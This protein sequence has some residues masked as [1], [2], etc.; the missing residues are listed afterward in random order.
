MELCI[1]NF[2]VNI[3]QCFYMYIDSLIHSSCMRTLT[4]LS[5]KALEYIAKRHLQV[6]YKFYGYNLMNFKLSLTQMLFL[7]LY[8]LV[9]DEFLFKKYCIHSNFPLC[10]SLV[11]L[12]FI[13]V[14]MCLRVHRASQKYNNS[15]QERRLYFL[16][17]K[18]N[19]QSF[20]RLKY[21]SSGI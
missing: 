2:I 19:Y 10:L 1:L 15:M 13:Y 5:S 3:L 14:G 9:F 17:P 7:F 6:V 20:G 8:L 11:I 12:R 16:S 18:C 4:A 21:V